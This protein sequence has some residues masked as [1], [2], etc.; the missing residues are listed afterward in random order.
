MSKLKRN[1]WIERNDCPQ[2]VV[3][4]CLDPHDDTEE[5]CTLLWRNWAG[6]GG[7][8]LPGV[9]YGT[10]VAI[11]RPRIRLLAKPEPGCWYLSAD[12]RGK[13]DRAYTF[14]R[15]RPRW[16]SSRG[17]F[18]APP[19][20]EGY[21]PYVVFV[22]AYYFEELFPTIKIRARSVKPIAPVTLVRKD[23]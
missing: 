14:W 4:G 9:P 12:I 7:A 8:W 2:D 23:R 13:A 18:S 17:Q 22:C 16:D 10:R 6:E 11:Q 3:I 5:I 20:R 19:T 15:T 1:W 21:D